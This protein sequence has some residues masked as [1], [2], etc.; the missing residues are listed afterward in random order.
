MG[1]CFL[2]WKMRLYSAKWKNEN[3]WDNSFEHQKVYKPSFMNNASL[4]IYGM[5][6]LQQS[7]L[8]TLTINKLLKVVGKKV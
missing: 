3:M 2:E 5:N 6:I 8:V 1:F 7:S 4:L